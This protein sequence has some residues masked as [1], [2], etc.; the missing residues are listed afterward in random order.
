MCK[1]YTLEEVRAIRGEIGK[2]GE[3]RFPLLE[4][5][6]DKAKAELE[7]AMTEQDK[8]KAELNKTGAERDKIRAQR[9]KAIAEYDIKLFALLV[10]ICPEAYYRG[11]DGYLVIPRN[12]DEEWIIP[13]FTG[14]YREIK[15][16]AFSIWTIPKESCD[17]KLAKEVKEDE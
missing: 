17:E 1:Y 8:T 2:L 15:H 14:A 4:V 13:I 7:K 5:K 3:R 6:L 12:E 10:V 11:W 16:T 9:D